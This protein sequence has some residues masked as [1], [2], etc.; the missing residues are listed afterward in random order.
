MDNAQIAEI[1]AEGMKSLTDLP[2]TPHFQETCTRLMS[3]MSSKPEI[4][5]TLTTLCTQVEREVNESDLRDAN[6]AET[7]A[8]FVWAF[9]IIFIILWVANG[10]RTTARSSTGYSAT[11]KDVYRNGV[12]YRGP[13]SRGGREKPKKNKKRR[14]VKRR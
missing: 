6:R 1:Y 2:R 12:L 13:K 11:S 7:S 10:G 5:D 14:T 3:I 9:A 4:M 8:A